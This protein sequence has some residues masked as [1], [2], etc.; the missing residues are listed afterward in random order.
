MTDIRTIWDVDRSRGD[1]RISGGAL[2]SGSDLE[3]A[4]LISLFTDRRAMP[5]DAIPD[6]TDD[7]RGWWGDDQ[8]DGTNM[9]IGSRLWLIS[10]AKQTQATLN[11]AVTYAREA[12]QWL[13]SDGVAAAVDVRAE[14]NGRG[15]LAMVVTIARNDGT[16][17]AMNFKWAWEQI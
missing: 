15:F 14:W 12:L 9:P 6:G 7:P 8:P 4:V 11:S 3:T 17:H 1:W 16:S 10:R 2:D 13:V 5:G